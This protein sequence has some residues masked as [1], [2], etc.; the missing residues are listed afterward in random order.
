MDKIVQNSDFIDKERKG[1]AFEITSA[2]KIA[3]WES[4]VRAKSPPL[5]TYFESW[6]KLRTVKRNRQA[7]DAEKIGDYNLPSVKRVR[8]E[9]VSKEPANP[10]PSD[11]EDDGDQGEKEVSVS[12]VKRKRVKSKKRKLAKV[13]AESDGDEEAVGDVVEDF[14]DNDW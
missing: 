6:N 14:N 3:A 8:K 4:S 7:T 1:I 2:A 13:A 12:K 10:F 11:D 9:V 5:S